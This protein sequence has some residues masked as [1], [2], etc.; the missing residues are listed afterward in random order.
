MKLTVA[1]NSDLPPEVRLEL[2][3]LVA[4]AT[5]LVRNHEAVSVE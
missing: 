2:R 1:D 3:I 5:I 4:L